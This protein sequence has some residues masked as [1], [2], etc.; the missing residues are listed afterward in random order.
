MGRGGF[1]KALHE[2]LAGP[3]EAGGGCV[4]LLAEARFSFK[5]S[6]ALLVILLRDYDMD[7][8]VISVAKSSEMY[9]RV[10]SRRVATRHPPYYIEVQASPADAGG[11]AADRV[12]LSAFDLDR[13]DTAV[14]MGLHRAGERFGGERHFV[15]LDD[16]TAIEAYNGPAVVQRFVRRFFGELSALNIFCFVVLPETLAGGLL[17][18]LPFSHTER[19]CVRSEWFA[20]G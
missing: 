18:V 7:G 14:R 20:W 5:A 8:V 9:R 12:E 15:L 6:V 11:D 16:L 4:Q 10:L 17:G 13:I 2:A 3:L 19:I 1:E